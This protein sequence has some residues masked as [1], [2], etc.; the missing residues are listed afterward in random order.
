MQYND[1]GKISLS[2]RQA[3]TIFVIWIPSQFSNSWFS[4]KLFF[5]YFTMSPSFLGQ[6]HQRS[7]CSF[8]IR[9]FCGQLFCAY[10]LGLY[11]IGARLLA[12]KLRLEHWW[13]WTLVVWRRCNGKSCFRSKKP[14]GNH[15]DWLILWARLWDQ[16]RI[17]L[18]I[19]SNFV[20]SQSHA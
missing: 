8:Y 6:F 15:S 17:N 18:K 14:R 11:F 19:P 12:Q 9:K 13:N 4:G 7:T 16:L 3:L 2:F 1:D 20:L 10:I 5:K